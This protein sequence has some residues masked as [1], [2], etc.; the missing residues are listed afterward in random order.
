MTVLAR[1]LQIIERFG[2]FQTG[3]RVGV[4]VSGGADSVCLL[5]LLF[6]LAARWNLHLHVLHVDHQL[7]GDESC[8]DA[9]FVGQLAAQLGLPFSQSAVDVAGLAAQRGGNLEETARDERRRYFLEFLRSGALDRIALGHTRSDQAETVLFRFLRGSGSAGLAGIRPVTADGFVRPLLAVDRAEVEQFLR[10]R[11]IAWRLDSTNSHLDFARNRIR[12]ELLPLLQREWNAAIVEM[13]AHTADWALEEESY[14][15]TEIER[16]S[17]KYLQIKPP[18]VLLRADQLTGLAVAAARR[19]V[20]RALETVKGD[21]RAIDF[22]H[23]TA[24]LILASQTQGDGRL[25][26]PGVD[27]YRSFEWLRL[28]P[29]GLD[30]LEN[31]NFRISVSSPGRVSLPGAGAAILLEL[32]E[33]KPVTE[34]SDSRYNKDVHY[35][36]GDRVS[37]ALEVRNWRPGDQYWPIDHSGEEK[38]K[39]LFQQARIPLWERRSWP[40]ITSADRIIWVR[41]FGPAADLAATPES[42][43]LLK[44]QEVLE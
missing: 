29:P 13:L 10:E 27:V 42:R 6:D 32:I 4:A 5:H 30:N 33:N 14:W 38:I 34:L 1:V 28:A 25:Q 19:L 35:L 3:Q 7:R 15:E 23:I 17:A 37:S 41:Q 43:V 40:V 22:S 26:V 24:V 36:D 8:A 9:R 16:L 20:R 21:L 2:M 39:L 31:R 11:N 44:V 12:H 18:I